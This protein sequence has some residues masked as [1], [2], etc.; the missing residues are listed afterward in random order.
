MCQIHIRP[1]N[2]GYLMSTNFARTLE[3]HLS[4]FICLCA[5]AEDI[6]INPSRNVSFSKTSLPTTILADWKAQSEEACLLYAGRF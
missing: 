5:K 3:Q 1:S 2:G 4:I 6:A